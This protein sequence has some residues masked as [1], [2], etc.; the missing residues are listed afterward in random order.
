MT[1]NRETGVLISGAASPQG[2]ALTSYMQSVFEHDFASAYDLVIGS[3]GPAELAI[4]KNPQYID[5]VMPNITVAS[6]MYV[7]PAP[8][9][10]MSSSSSTTTAQASPDSAWNTIQANINSA[11]SAIQIAMYQ[12]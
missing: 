11:K 1:K 7:T 2:A 5:I 8:Q 12:V 4:I 10:L 9:L 3:W 6:G